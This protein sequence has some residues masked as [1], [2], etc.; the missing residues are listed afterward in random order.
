[1]DILSK[2]Q[3][4][5]LQYTFLLFLIVL[6]TYI[7]S[8]TLDISILPDI[9]KIIDFK[10]ILL[11]FGLVLLYIL[12][13]GYIIKIILNSI[14]NTKCK[15]LGFKVGTIGLY[16]NLVTP[17]ASG[18]Q[19]MQVYVLN[20]FNVPISKAIA[21]IVNKT[22]VF[23]TIVTVYTGILLLINCI[24]LKNQMNS[25][26]LLISTGMIMNI[27]MLSFGFLII[28]NP[29]KTKFIVNLILDI[30]K[31]IKIF[32][33]LENKR[34]NID[35][36]IDEY[37]YSV[38]LFLKDKKNLIKALML[39]IIQLTFHFSIAYCIYKSF[40]LTSASFIQMVALQAFLYM[41]VSPVPTPGNVGANEIVFFT[42]FKGIFPKD[43]IGYSVF[44]YGIFVYYFILL[45]CG[46]CT[47]IIHYKMKKCKVSYSKYIY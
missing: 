19:P 17:L 33:K 3:K 8:T 22:V 36:F 41:A 2:R 30:L 6:T 26:M 37:Y 28:Y 40:N 29:K 5:I 23:Q 39:T 34:K 13:E 35:K 44:V 42:I 25:I 16:Y 12:L 18:S 20:K 11:G 14:H 10:Y 21:V 46:I 4:D 38:R 7:V 9:I 24:Y 15:F 45:F 43:L 31:K 47:I 32:K 1:M 27:I